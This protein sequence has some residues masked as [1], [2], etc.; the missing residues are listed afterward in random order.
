MTT[1]PLW[2]T[3]PG[4]VLLVLTGLATLI[5]SIGLMR[6]PDFFTR[7]HGPSLTTT[8]GAGS[9]LVTSLLV[10]SALAGRPIIH[11]VL[12]ALLLSATAPVTS[13]MLVQAALYRN[14]AR[15][16]R[17]VTPSVSDA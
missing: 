11:E 17:R 12:I 4:S 14:K 16:T 3:I 1:L 6:L 7:M 8:V 2:V 13:I 9:L 10:T 15:Q 5:G